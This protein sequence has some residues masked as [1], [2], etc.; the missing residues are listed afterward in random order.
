MHELP[1]GGRFT[2]DLL[3]SKGFLVPVDSRSGS[4]NRQVRSYRSE[5]FRNRIN[6]SF[7][8]FRFLGLFGFLSHMI[9]L[10]T[11]SSNSRPSKKLGRL[12]GNWVNLARSSSKKRWRVRP[13]AGTQCSREQ[14]YL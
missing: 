1:V 5:A 3:R 6:P 4:I 7:F 9:I 11:G 12:L 10:D 14:S 2:D 13:L 8:G